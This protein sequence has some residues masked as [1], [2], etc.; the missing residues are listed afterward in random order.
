[1]EG[2]MYGTY[3]ADQVADTI[4]ALTTA[5]VPNALVQHPYLQTLP[6]YCIS[7]AN[8][9]DFV[10]PC[11][12]DGGPARGPMGR[13]LLTLALR[14][15]TEAAWYCREAGLL[16]ATSVRTFILLDPRRIRPETP[17]FNPSAAFV[18]TGYAVL[19]DGYKRGTAFMAFK[20]GP[21]TASIGHNHYDHNSF[22]INYAGEW[23]A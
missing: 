13:L 3:A 4:W 5:G 8:P 18:D 11:F 19:R 16:E 20:A 6:R 1:M 10:T 9:N 7:L 2:P 17:T 12:G 23:L 22:V 15:D 14:G 21:P